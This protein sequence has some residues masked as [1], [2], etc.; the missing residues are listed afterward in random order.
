MTTHDLSKYHIFLASGENVL[1][2]ALYDLQD[3][4]PEKTRPAIEFAPLQCGDILICYKSQIDNPVFKLMGEIMG[5]ESMPVIPLIIIERKRINDFCSSY[6]SG[7]LLSQRARLSSFREQTGC[8][9]HLVVEGYYQ[10]IVKTYNNLHGFTQSALEQAFVSTGV[11]DKFILAHVKD[12][13]GHADYIYQCLKSIEKYELYK[14]YSHVT[15]QS[16]NDS[17]KFKDKTNLTPKLYYTRMISGLPMFSMDIAEKITEIYPTFSS[18]LAELKTNDI[19]NIKEIK[20]GKNKLGNVKAQRL[21][22]YLL[23]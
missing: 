9:C 4:I 18:L 22:E 1:M 3:K 23:L 5:K 21:I 11:R 13:E 12:I 6:K 19:N 15:Q 14:G 2:Q 17:L 20:L 10:E 16:Y 7:R 8:Q